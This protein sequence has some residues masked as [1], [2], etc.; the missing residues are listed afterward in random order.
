MITL[1]GKQVLKTFAEKF[2]RH[3]FPILI[4]IMFFTVLAGC[5]TEKVKPAAT[6][7]S[8]PPEN[9]LEK[10]ALANNQRD[11]VQAVANIE[12]SSEKGR[13][14]LKVALILK[15]PSF[16]RVET[17]PLVGTP[18]FFL[19]LQ[20]DTLKIFLPLKKEFY[21]CRATAENL[22]LFLPISIRIEDMVP[23]LMGIPPPLTGPAKGVDKS[24]AILEG[25]LYRIDMPS[26]DGKRQTIWI[27]RATGDL[28]K[29]EI[30][31]DY[32]L[33]YTVLY[34]EYG[35]EGGIPMPRKVIITPDEPGKSGVV[36][37]YSDIRFSN[38][39]DMTPFD[40]AVPPG[41]EPITLH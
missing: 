25:N 8:P 32:R 11:T 38:M 15:R 7:Y 40:L 19:S 17:I 41:M 6:T 10:I 28:V 2:Y 29:V 18:D 12:I 27:D 1:G 39:T 24:P 35:E 21:I 16:L 4:L 33:L 37:R 23:I 30:F 14:P 36:I 34:E 22:A 3:T 13:Y 20:G 31:E 9:I 5:G 26:G